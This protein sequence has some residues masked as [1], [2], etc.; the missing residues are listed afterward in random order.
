MFFLELL[1]G[2]RFVVRQRFRELYLL[3]ML[4]EF[5]VANAFEFQKAV[6]EADYFA[7]T[8]VGCDPALKVLYLL[9]YHLPAAIS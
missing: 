7:C 3:G 4:P 1:I 6:A 2:L 5:V 8:K 9:R